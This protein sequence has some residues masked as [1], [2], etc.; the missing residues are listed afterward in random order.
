M[1]MVAYLYFRMWRV[2]IYLFSVSYVVF[3]PANKRTLTIALK[4][5]F[6]CQ[7]CNESAAV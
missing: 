7:I 4:I 2:F 5:G 3:I 6:I 1:A